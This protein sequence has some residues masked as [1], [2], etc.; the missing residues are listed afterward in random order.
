[1]RRRTLA[2]FLVIC[3]LACGP[4]P[5]AE[6]RPVTI[7]IVDQ[8]G[9]P[10]P[11]R[12]YVQSLDDRSWHYVRP[13]G[14]EGTAFRYEKQ[15]W[16]NRDAVEYHTTVSAGPCIADLPDGR[17]RLTVERGKEYF[18]EVREIEVA[19]EPLSCRCRCGG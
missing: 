15:N 19:G 14:D 2:L 12:V 3:T 18:P 11:A 1:M 7:E 6:T 10:L 13:A 16:N 8:A 9:T 5:A 4:L 17:Y